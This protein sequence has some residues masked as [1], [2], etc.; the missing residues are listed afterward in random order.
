MNTA[1]EDVACRRNTLTE[2]SSSHL[3][4]KIPTGAESIEWIQLSGIEMGCD[5]RGLSLCNANEE[6]N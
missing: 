6:I 2:G 5:Y 4:L 1:Q 3:G